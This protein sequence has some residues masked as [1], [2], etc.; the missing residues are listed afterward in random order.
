M[1][2]KNTGANPYGIDPAIYADI[3]KQAANA[4]TYYNSP[5]QPLQNPVLYAKELDRLVQRERSGNGGSGLT[6]D[7]QSQSNSSSFAGLEGTERDQIKGLLSQMIGGGTEAYKQAQAQRQETIGMLDSAL[8]QYSKQAAFSDAAAMMQQN[9]N[10]SMEANQPAIQRAMQNAG[11]S[12]GSMQ[13]LLSQKLANDAALSAGTLGAEQ[14][15]AYGQISSSFM[16]QRGALTTGQDQ[17]LDPIA[18]LAE[19]LKVSRSSGSSIGNFDPLRES[20][21]AEDRASRERIASMASGGAGASK[22]S[23]YGPDSVNNWMD[24]AGSYDRA[25]RQGKL[26]P[27][28]PENNMTYGNTGLY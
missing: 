17:S 21:A 22:W 9:L 7:T 23:T 12:G 4:A 3:Q 20:M 15:K 16:N 13:A 28:A 11:T 26:N 6:G 27:L 1:V 8:N 24:S 14:A 18:R 5:G 10:K 2:T 19:T 25:V